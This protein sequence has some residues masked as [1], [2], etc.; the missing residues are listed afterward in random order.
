M[1]C[2]GNMVDTQICPT[3]PHSFCILNGLTIVHTG[4]TKFLTIFC[5]LPGKLIFFF[6]IILTI[7]CF[8]CCCW[9]FE[10]IRFV[11]QFFH[12][13]SFGNLKYFLA[14]KTTYR[15]YVKY[16]FIFP[17]SISVCVCAWCMDVYTLSSNSIDN[18]NLFVRDEHQRFSYYC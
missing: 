1:W 3:T 17:S 16:K 5:I 10:L 2:D 8:G 18:N 9:V 7:R 6:V 14:P 15:E 11:I 4:Y 12:W 13:L